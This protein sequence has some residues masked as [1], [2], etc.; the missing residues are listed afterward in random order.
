MNFNSKEQLSTCVDQAINLLERVEDKVLEFARIKSELR[1]LVAASNDVPMIANY[2]L[3][4]AGK[5]TLF[6]ALMDERELFATA[7]VRCTTE[8]QKHKAHGIEFVDTPGLDAN[9]QD[10]AEAKDVLQRASLVLFVH[11]ATNGELD[12]DELAALEEIS[13]YFPESTLKERCFLP[14][15][16]KCEGIREETLGQ[17]KEKILQQWKTTTG[18]APSEIFAVRSETYFRGKE[19]KE[20]KLVEHSQIPRLVEYLQNEISSLEENQIALACQRAETLFKEATEEAK[21]LADS[22]RTEATKSGIEIQ[23][24]FRLIRS[25]YNEMAESIVSAHNARP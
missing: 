13:S 4:K 16:T 21:R 5:S 25:D 17:V 7:D 9:E 3:L 15:L 10:T 12:R 23:R 1:K 11:S 14:V 18:V 22:K 19:K 6:N 20:A 24:R 8:Q 2:G